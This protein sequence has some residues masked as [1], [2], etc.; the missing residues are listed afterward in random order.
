MTCENLP[1]KYT[2]YNHC[3]NHNFVKIK[4][5]R[6]WFH[7]L[8]NRIICINKTRTEP[9]FDQRELTLD[10]CEDLNSLSGLSTG[11]SA[12]LNTYKQRLSLKADTELLGKNRNKRR[13]SKWDG[14][15]A[16]T[17][18]LGY[19]NADYTNSVEKVAIIKLKL[20]LYKCVFYEIRF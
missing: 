19:L 11:D 3:I 6:N 14:F 7:S 1:R 16:G 13:M 4:S 17:A 12:V 2:L 18:S 8:V 15:H 20:T 10:S 5:T 9:E